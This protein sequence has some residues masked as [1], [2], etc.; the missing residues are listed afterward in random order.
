M[1]TSPLPLWPVAL[2]NTRDRNVLPPPVH[3]CLNNL[4][5]DIKSKLVAELKTMKWAPPKISA[6]FINAVIDERSFDKIAQYI[7]NA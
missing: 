2:L 7:D 5:D 6:I 4:A 1:W 3:I